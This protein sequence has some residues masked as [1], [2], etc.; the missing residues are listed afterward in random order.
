MSGICQELLRTMKS[1]QK[2]FDTWNL[3]KKQLEGCGHSFLSFHERQIW[4]CSLGLNLGDEQDGKNELFERPVL[5]FRKFNNRI[6]WVIPLTS[7]CKEGPYYFALPNF[8]ALKNSYLILSQVR[9]VSAKRLR[10]R[11]ARISSSQFHEI[12]KRFVALVFNKNRSLLSEAP[13]EAQG[14]L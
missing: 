9:L 5:V 11:M 1:M 8:G 10:R 12:Q 3:E 7:K 14:H 2:D 6:A 13:R 4:W